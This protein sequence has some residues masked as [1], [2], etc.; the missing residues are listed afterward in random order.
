MPGDLAD[1]QRP[2]EERYSTSLLPAGHPFLSSVTEVRVY[3]LREASLHQDGTFGEQN[4]Q[5]YWFPFEGVLLFG[6]R[7]GCS[8][9]LIDRRALPF[10]PLSSAP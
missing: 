3:F 4:S 6:S 1:A 10:L 8:G 7:Y 9:A 2:V 5:G